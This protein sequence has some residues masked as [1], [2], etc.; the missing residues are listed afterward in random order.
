MKSSSIW[1]MLEAHAE[2]SDQVRSSRH[3]AAIVYKGQVLSLGNNKLKT[4]P[5]MLKYGKNDKSIYLHA[6]VDAIVRCINKFG[7]SILSN[8]SLYVLRLDKMNRIC[9]SKPCE[10]CQKAIEAFGVRHVY[11]T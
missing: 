1:S 8:C 7:S 3:A 11:Y 2:H 10:G 4:H 6:E 9:I 5:I